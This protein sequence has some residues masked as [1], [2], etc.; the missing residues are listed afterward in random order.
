MKIYNLDTIAP[1]IAK[2]ATERRLQ[3]E[4]IFFR[5]FPA[6]FLELRFIA[7][8]DPEVAHICALHLFHF[9]NREE[10]VLTQ[11]EKGVAL[12]TAHLFEIENV[13]VKR[14]RLLDIIHFDR[15]MIASINL[16]AHIAA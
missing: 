11:F 3:L 7:N 6:N 14:H 8:H 13:F 4:F 5:Q 15:D 9:E 2:I 1:R 10:L 12:A 16:H